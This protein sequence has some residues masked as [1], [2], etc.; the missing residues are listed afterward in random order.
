MQHATLLRCSQANAVLLAL[1]SAA[2]PVPAAEE[3][4]TEATQARITAARQ[5]MEKATVFMRSISTEGGYVYLYSPDLQ[6]RT[7]ERPT[8][9]TQIAIQPPGT[10]SMGLAF[11][12]AYEATHAAVFL[13][14]ARAAATAL[15]RCQLASGGWHATADF[16]PA[17]PNVDGKLYGGENYKFGQIIKHTIGTTFDDDT[18]QSAVRFLLQFAKVTK[19]SDKP[20][21]VAIHQSLDRALTGMMRAQ[22]PN[23]AWPQ[24]YRGE[25]RDPKDFPIKKASIPQDYPRTWPDAD[26]TGYYTLNDNGHSTCVKTMLLAYQITGKPEHL[27]SARRGADFLLLAQL[28]EPQPAWAQQY[29]RYME[30]AWARMH[31]MPSACSAESGGVIR[32]LLD[33]YLETGDEKYLSAAAPAVAWLQRSKIGKNLW[34]RLYELGTNKPVYGD[35]RGRIFYSREELSPKF[36]AGYVW[37]S[38][39]KIPEV[40]ADYERLKNEGREA[41]LAAA[42]TPRQT[43]PELESSVDQILAALDSQGRW[44][45]DERWRKGHPPEP[46]IS[47]KTYI[48]NIETLADYLFQASNAGA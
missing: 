21:D 48:Q 20:E 26:Y 47:T 3:K 18:T 27:E 17:R 44:I 31:E 29:N 38:K 37:E 43:F 2:F 36:A 13:D 28:P 9:A 23:G 12:R 32:A 24:M 8:S 19:D 40:L 30:P 42:K 1:C 41:F 16:D 35:E 14:A 6:K 25:A 15:A 4:Q 5:A 33:T 22:Y 46:S 7:A 11:L 45:T 34:A 39:F 10:P